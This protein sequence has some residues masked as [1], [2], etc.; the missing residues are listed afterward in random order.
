MIKPGVLLACAFV[1][2]LLLTAAEV[3]GGH[4]KLSCRE[5]H[6][7]H[8][9]HEQDTGLSAKGLW[10]ASHTA[11]ELPVFTLYSSRSFDSLGIDVGQ[12][13][14]TSRLCLG[15][16][17][18]SFGQTAPLAGSVSAPRPVDLARSHPISFTYDSALAARVRGDALRDPAIA[19][20]GLGGT[21]AADLLDE[22]GKVQCTSCHDVH[23][24]AGA[25]KLLRYEYGGA[26]DGDR[27]L[28]RV[29]HN[30]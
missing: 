19:P 29:C 3:R 26:A 20:S 15:C 30:L 2:L 1:L 9:A 25:S 24:K 5:C 17:D 6:V 10:N 12:P 7:V 16:H 18:G 21:I 4:E 22:S 28:C 11:D 23:A 14:G 13:D 8:A 27:Y